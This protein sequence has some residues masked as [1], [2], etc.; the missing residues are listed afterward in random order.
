MVR[1]YPCKIVV[2]NDILEDKLF[3]ALDL[4]VRIVHAMG[5]TI[6]DAVLSFDTSVWRRDPG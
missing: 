4:S 5:S 1:L 3:L 2:A 6:L